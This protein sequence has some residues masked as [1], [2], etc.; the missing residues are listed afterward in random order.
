MQQGVGD[1]KESNMK[2]LTL[3]LAGDNSI[4]IKNLGEQFQFGN[5]IQLLKKEERGE[6]F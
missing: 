4:E 6:I 2:F 3:W 5:I 1:E